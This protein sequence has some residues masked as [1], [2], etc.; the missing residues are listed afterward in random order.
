MLYRPWC[1]T[2]LIRNIFL[3]KRN[4]LD[5]LFYCFSRRIWMSF[6]FSILSAENKEA[7]TSAAKSIRT[8]TNES[9]NLF[10]FSIV[11]WQVFSIA[12]WQITV[13]ISYRKL[14]IKLFVAFFRSWRGMGGKGRRR[15]TGNISHF[16]K[17]L[18]SHFTSPF[19]RITTLE[20]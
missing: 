10:N 5:F 7:S 9:M 3:L 13:S 16:H 15:R 17:N 2:V 4:V 12:K 11:K 6:N 1:F 14:S 8:F 18:C 20:H 19:H